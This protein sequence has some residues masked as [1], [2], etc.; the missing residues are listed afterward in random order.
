MPHVAYFG[1]GASLTVREVAS[2]GAEVLDSAEGLRIPDPLKHLVISDQPDV[3]HGSYGVE[4]GDE[5][6]LVVRCGE[7]CSVVIQTERCSVAGVMSFEVLNQHFV[8]SFCIRWCCTGV[9][10]GT[11]SAVQ[12]LPHNHRDLPYTWE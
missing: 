10:H 12:I 2:E 5:T 3:I 8:N 7:P 4:E 6:F 11:P 9:A 1:A